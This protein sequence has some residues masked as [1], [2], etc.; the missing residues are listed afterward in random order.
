VRSGKGRK[1]CDSSS[2]EQDEANYFAMHLLV[3]T[4]MLL[5][6]LNGDFSI[7]LA[8][9]DKRVKVLARRYGVTTQMMLLR[10][11]EEAERRK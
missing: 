1:V 11:I 7:D 9:E 8:D 3:P 2:N 10:I 4:E 6:D 5:K